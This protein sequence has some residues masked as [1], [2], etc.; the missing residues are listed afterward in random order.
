M[1][2]EHA[3]ELAA[4]IGFNAGYFY[5][6]WQQTRS[7]KFPQLKGAALDAVASSF[8]MKRKPARFWRWELPWNESDSSFRKRQVEFLSRPPGRK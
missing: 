5:A 1:S 7:S 4:A 8:G 2:H 3:L 6:R